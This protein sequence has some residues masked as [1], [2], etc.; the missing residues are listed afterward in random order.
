[1][2][3]SDGNPHDDGVQEIDTVATRI[4]SLISGRMSVEEAA[5][6]FGQLSA[7]NIP[8]TSGG[9]TDGNKMRSDMPFGIIHR[10]ILWQLYGMPADCHADNDVISVLHELYTNHHDGNWSTMLSR[11]H[12][13]SGILYDD[14]PPSRHLS[15]DNISL[16]EAELLD[17][18]YS[19][20]HNLLSP[21]R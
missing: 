19:Y 4:A 5:Y 14:I 7:C 8:D 17:R 20:Y 10:M 13:L 12:D 18:V 16:S 3:V 15:F 11:L 9:N 2:C 1:M 6:L 21:I